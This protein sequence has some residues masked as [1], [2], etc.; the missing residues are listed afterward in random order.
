[1]CDEV[2]CTTPNR[3]FRLEALT[4]LA[5]AAPTG[6]ASS[7]AGAPASSF[8][9]KT[10][11]GNGGVAPGSSETVYVDIT[12]PPPGA[13]S[14][15]DWTFQAVTPTQFTMTP[16]GSFTGFEPQ[17]TYDSTAS[18]AYSLNG[19]L[20][21]PGFAPTSE[22][23]NTN[24]A[25][26]IN[27]SNAST[28]QDPFPDYLDL[29]T[30]DLP[31]TNAFTNASGMPAGWSLL[32]TSTPSAGISRY[33]FGLCAGQFV[34]A[35][36]PV[37]NPPP[38]NAPVPSCGAA[39][40]ASAMAPGQTFSVTGNLQ[41]GVSNITGTMYAHGAN[42]SGW[43][44]AHTFNLSIA[45]VSAT[46]GFSAAGGYPS[47]GAVTSPNT[48][49][50]GADADTTFGTA[51]TYVIKNT[52]GAG[53]NLTSAV[54]TVP[55][56][57][58]SFV[59]PADGTAWTITSAPV[60]SGAAYGCSITSYTSAQ[61]NGTNGAINIG[62]GTCSVT[63]GSTLTIKF[64]AKAPYTVN[65]TYTFPTKVN[66]AIAAS[67]QWSTDSIVQIILAASLS[68]SVNPGNPGPGGSS[69][70]VNCPACVFNTGTNTVDLGPVANLQ[71]VTGGDVVRVSVYTNAGTSVGWKLYAS[72]NVNPANTGAPTNELL[73]A[74]D[75]THSA[76]A[77]GINYDQTAYAVIPTTNP[78]LLLMDTGTGHAAQRLPF[79]EVMNFQVSI[80]GGPITPATSVVT[81]TF[82]SN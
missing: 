47:G 76:P 26:T 24:N 62:G 80:Q 18:A 35:D 54:I 7:V 53:N 29:I 74:I 2:W 43:S 44:T 38:V 16:A 14:F 21:T 67:E 20:I 70:S 39:T 30:V 12:P 69:P 5:S 71:T 1:M 78:G 81:Y 55:G 9:L 27:V 58:A 6:P 15:T 42:G 49:Q 22:G 64:T 33:W 52:S 63:P 75:S 68:I 59:L 51:F 56:K 31:S 10:A 13:F 57:D 66:G 73:T 17:N 41:T 79:D 48:P 11:G 32:G 28:A 65:D 46:A 82:I 4:T 19:N 50:I 61:T 37:T 40:E 60:I 34:T 36:G 23:Q 77:A 8:C 45:A 25:V 3:N 72:T